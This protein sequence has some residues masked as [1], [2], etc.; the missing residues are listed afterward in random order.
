[1]RAA[2][3][4]PLSGQVAIVTGASGGIGS[5]TVR[6][7]LAAGA[8]VVLAAPQDALLDAIAQEMAP[9]GARAMIV[10]TD[11]T[12]R[13]EVDALVARTLVRFERIDVLANV[14]G[15][16]ASPSLAD[17]TD[18][19]IERVLAVNLLGA[20]RAIHAVLPVMKAQRRGA[21]VNIGSIAGETAIMGIYS[22]SKFGLRG[23]NDSVRREVR[24]YNIGVTLIE[25]GFVATPMNAAMRGLPGP[26][27]VADAIVAAI[28]KPR[29]KRIVPANYRLPVFLTRALPGFT[30][31]VFGDARIQR[32]L[33]RD[34]RAARAAA[35]QPPH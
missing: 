18:D 25:P 30:D 3:A 11:I 12:R 27:V 35:E 6:A 24:S 13:E 5:A 2:P 20:A 33:N 23:L 34:A 16:G 7:L 9:F 15:I 19:E 21:I 14:A 22:A 17:C 29:R 32:R 10:P 26:E 1:M 28:T 31:L 4:P 8:Y